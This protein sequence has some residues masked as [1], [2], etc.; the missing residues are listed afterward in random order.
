MSV[1]TSALPWLAC[2]ALA[3]GPGAARAGGGKATGT[4]IQ[5]IQRKRRE[6]YPRE[7]PCPSTG[8][9]SGNC[10]GY[11]VGYV[12]LPK[13][14][15]RYETANMRWMTDDEAVRTGQDLRW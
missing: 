4:G 13:H 1:A 10:P 5:E 6:A 15:G 14:G 12:V 9:T 2:A 8:K 7:H 11:V 3:L